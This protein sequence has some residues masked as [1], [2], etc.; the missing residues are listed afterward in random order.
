MHLHTYINFIFKVWCSLEVLVS[1]HL[2][3]NGSSS[4]D[5]VYLTGRAAM[6]VIK[7]NDKISK[8]GNGSDY[9]MYLFWNIR[10]FS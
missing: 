10:L 7:N 8:Q 3:M 1:T 6:Q 9:S 2:I 4:F 5:V